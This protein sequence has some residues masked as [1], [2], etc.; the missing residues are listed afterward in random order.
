MLLVASIATVVAIAF[1]GIA[2]VAF[3]ARMTDASFPRTV[4]QAPVE[5]SRDVERVERVERV[6]VI[7]A[8]EQLGQ[9]SPF[10]GLP[11]GRGR[12]W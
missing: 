7:V 4:Q 1:M 11:D 5:R 3:C 2:T 9:V 10:L 6:I 8:P 12:G